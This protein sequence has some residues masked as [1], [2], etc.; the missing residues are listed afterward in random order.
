MAGAHRLGNR[1]CR[2]PRAY[3]P[4]AL[5]GGPGIRSHPL[6]GRIGARV[7][8]I[9]LLR[10]RPRPHRRPPSMV[11]WRPRSRRGV[12]ASI[13][14]ALRP[15]GLAHSSCGASRRRAD[16]LRLNAGHHWSG[17]PV[18]TP[19]PVALPRGLNPPPKGNFPAMPRH[20]PQSLPGE[21]SACLYW[22]GRA[23]SCSYNSY[24]PRPAVATPAASLLAVS[25]SLYDP[26]QSGNKHEANIWLC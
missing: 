21:C 25:W 11:T 15:G 19:R 20:E 22:N 7:A 17:Y 18:L 1:I 8:A 10:R 16:T 5:E 3:P 9:S 23:R 26:K 24:V 4:E 13:S 6:A 2:P 12:T 14:F